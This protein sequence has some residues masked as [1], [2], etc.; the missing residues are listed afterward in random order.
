MLT[1]VK[2]KKKSSVLLVYNFPKSYCR[3]LIT[4]FHSDK[5][6]MII[7]MHDNQTNMTY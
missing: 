7:S 2:G 6:L 4:P 5:L 3:M 1:D